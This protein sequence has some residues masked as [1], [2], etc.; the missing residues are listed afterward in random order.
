MAKPLYKV[1]FTS[2]F[3]FSKLSS[4]INNIL[5]DSNKEITDSIARNT[6]KNILT[7][8]TRRLSN[9]TIEARQ[10]G[11]SSFKGHN[12]SPTN[13]TRPL[14]YTGN[15]LNSIKPTKDGLEMMDYGLTHQEGF[16]T[17]EGKSVP[18]RPFIATLNQD[19]DA[20]KKVEERI[21]KRMN[22]KMMKR[23]R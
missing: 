4:D 20:L 18:P 15:L 3:R 13:E 17:S 7:A 21:V 14:H 2:N 22:G 12:P 6:K 10:K 19:K 9:A 23:S 8:S 5:S 1:T 16:T 11:V